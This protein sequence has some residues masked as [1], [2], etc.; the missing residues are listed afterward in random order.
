MNK[1]KQKNFCSLGRA[2]FSATGFMEA[3]AFAPPETRQ[4]PA[5]DHG[6]R[7]LSGSPE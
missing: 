3:K 6:S 7:K 4:Q 5:G 2:G 1:K